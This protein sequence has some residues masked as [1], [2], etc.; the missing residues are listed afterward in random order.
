MP[1][2]K[3]LRPAPL[4]SQG[5]TILELMIAASVFSI[6]LLVVAVGVLNF[7]N[8]YFKG[9]TTSKTQDA[10]RSVMNTL[11]QSIQ[12]GQTVTLPTYNS[13]ADTWGMCIDNTLYA[14]RLGQ[15]VTDTAP[16]PGINQGYHGLVASSGCTLPASLP[17][18]Q[19]LNN[20]REL[21]GEH[22]RLNTLSVTQSGNLYTIHVR[23][24]SGDN[25]LLTPNV[26][27]ST[28]W[29]TTTETCSGS[30]GT[31]FCAVADLTT[32]VEKRLL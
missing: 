12:F 32:T 13:S 24:I 22:M 10:A 15:Q 28:D 18:T 1:V 7:T 9:I 6:I 30:A 21:L 31:Q 26:T 16:Q 2:S 27:G 14:F 5:F 23:I 4:F 25:D 11:T 3:K 17:T 19:T 8:S 20:G 29:A